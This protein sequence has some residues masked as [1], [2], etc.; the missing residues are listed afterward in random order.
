MSIT[1]D[2]HDHIDFARAEELMDY[3]QNNRPF[4]EEAMASLG[5]FVIWLFKRP[6]IKEE[7]WEFLVDNRG[8]VFEH[9]GQ[10]FVKVIVDQEGYAILEVGGIMAGTAGDIID[11]LEK[12]YEL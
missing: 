4:G 8:V 6:K 5:D 1:L 3:F 12:D 11:T 10:P 9:Y 2:Q 7:N